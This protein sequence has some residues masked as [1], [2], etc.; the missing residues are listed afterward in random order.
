MGPKPKPQKMSLGSFLADEGTGTNWADDVSDLPSALPTGPRRDR[1]NAS[2]SYRSNDRGDRGAHTPRGE[3]PFPTQPPYNAYVGN[4]S[5]EATESDIENLF[6]GLKVKSVR[7]IRDP[8]GSFKGFGYCEFHDA[9][10]LRGAV[11]LHGQN[12]NGR[13]IKIDISESKPNSGQRSGRFDGERRDRSDT[14]F[15][16]IDDSPSDWRRRDP[17]AAQ[18]ASGSNGGPFGSGAREGGAF[19]GFRDRGDREGGLRGD[20]GDRDGGF[21]DRG[22][23]RE[24]GFRNSF[25]RD[26]PPTERKR[27]ELQPRS[28]D[29]GAP[30]S[31]VA[32]TADAPSTTNAAPSKP[33]PNPFGGASAR[34]EDAIMRR[35]EEKQQQK[36]AERR[37]ADAAGKKAKD[38]QKDA[39]LK[40][41]PAATTPNTSTPS[42]EGSWRRN[43][44]RPVTAN[45]NQQPA[46]TGYNKQSRGGYNNN[47]DSF[48]RKTATASF[49]SAAKP[50]ASPSKAVPAVA[51]IPPLS[52]M[53]KVQEVKRAN[54]FDVLNNEEEEI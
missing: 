10:S 39:S 40:Q 25:R 21:R 3:V 47:R 8:S 1:D 2:S 43:G 48:E 18:P 50:T 28:Q 32:A 6:A 46:A 15:S 45:K 4:L 14:R 44:P 22:G 52:P 53:K 51:A 11:A 7:L 16:N 36:E 12:V 30:T 5:F 19:G 35:I 34:D 13:S 33:K 20:R 41:K 24:G 9:D 42:D 27:L 31:A 26:E 23:D 29:S 54:V 49:E 17:Q 38:E 37:A